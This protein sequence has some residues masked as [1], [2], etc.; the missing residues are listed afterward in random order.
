MD[1]FKFSKEQEK[2]I[3][4]NWGKE[5]IHSMKLKFGCT[6]YAIAKLGEKN[7]LELPTSNEWTE[8]EINKLRRLS[9]KMH[10][11]K[12]A[13]VMGKTPN[14]VYIK[15]RRIGITLIQDRRKWT[16]N[17]EDYL[18]KKWG[19]NSINYIAVKL[20]RSVYSVKVKA[21]RMKLGPAIENTDFFTVSDLCEMLGV[22]RDRVTITWRKK[23][24]ALKEHYITDKKSYLVI[25]IDDLIKF[26][27]D[28]QDEWDSR[29]LE[30][31]GLGIEPKWLTE[32]RKQDYL[33][34]PVFYERWSAQEESKAIN[35]LLLGKD[36][37]EIAEEIG[38]SEAA[39]S[40]KL[41]DLGY[42]YRLKRFWKGVDFK[43][44]KDNYLTMTYSDIGDALG[45]TE[46]AVS[47]QASRL[48]YKKK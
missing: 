12:I 22:T 34:P 6:W 42:S 26:L 29:G 15:A 19:E 21:T 33:N 48:N 9:N 1:S 10:Y 37:S 44:L 4:D 23:G 5:S 3:L 38:R 14:A 24:L 13:K 8:K 7:G 46:K 31:Y 47:Y 35:L 36:Y 25:E 43:F 28:N 20:K 45:R 41:R 2:Y 32:K 39:V 27:K 40:V 11:E 16:K 18:S 17:E 30:L